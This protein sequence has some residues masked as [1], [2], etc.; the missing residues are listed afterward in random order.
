MLVREGIR[1]MTFSY[2]SHGWRVTLEQSINS[3]NQVLYKFIL[4]ISSRWLQCT[5]CKRKQFAFTPSKTKLPT[6]IWCN[7]NTLKPAKRIEKIKDPDKLKYRWE[8]TMFEDL[9][10][11]KQTLWVI[12]ITLLVYPF[13][14]IAIINWYRSTGSRHLRNMRT[15]SLGSQTSSLTSDDVRA[16]REMIRNSKDNIKRSSPPIHRDNPPSGRTINSS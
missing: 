13:I 12:E 5:K 2:L 3:L 9:I 7:T 4:I 6:C 15:S 11:I 14:V 16:L 10:Y 8:E 1:M